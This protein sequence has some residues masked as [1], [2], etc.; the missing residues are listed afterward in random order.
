MSLL[1]KVLLVSILLITGCCTYQTQPPVDQDIPSRNYGG[2]L[3]RAFSDS[4]LVLDPAHIKDSNSHEVCRQIYDGLVELDEEGTVIAAL[5]HSWEISADKLAY[6]F[7]LRDDI[8]F[9][10]HSGGEPTQNKGRKLVATD[11]LYSFQRILTPHEDS[12]G[13]FFWQIKGARQF[14]EGKIDSI[15]GIRVGDDH[16]VEFVLE[17]PF[18]PFISQLAMCNAF[19]VPIED[20]ATLKE[21]PVGTGPFRWSGRQGD[22]LILEANTEHFRGRPYLDKIEFLLIPDS[23][24]AYQ[25]FIRNELS[26]V[27]VPESEYRNVTRDQHLSSYLIEGALWGINYLGFKVQTPPFDNKLV[28]QAFNYAVDK[29]SIVQ[30]ILNGRVG[31]ASG[32]LPPGIPGYNPELAGYAYD[33]EKA[34]QLLASAGYP[35]GENFPEVVLQHNRDSIHARVAEFVVASLGDLG[36]SCRVKV[37]EFGEHLGKIERGDASFFRLGWTVDYPDPDS[38]LYTLFHSSNISNG[39]NFSGLKIDQVD[40]LLDKARVEIALETRIELYQKVEQII[41]DEAPWLF[42]YFYHNQMLYQPNVKGIKIGPMGPPL[43]NY[44]KIWLEKKVLQPE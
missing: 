25:A 42:L 33:L 18:A 8:H 23:L 3:S 31:R 9:H 32:V 29:E 39:Y 4:F 21:K 20:A 1:L 13:A 36:I 5:A 12:Q 19:I 28:R 35:D 16:C 22:S 30:L 6:K 27:E 44:R 41:V 15:E 37:L 34:R 17:K 40:E 11:V 26:L 7:F 2:T 43:L 10:A 24:E 14:S 38:F